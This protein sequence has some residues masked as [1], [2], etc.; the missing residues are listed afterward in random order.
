MVGESAFV[1]W[2]YAKEN[3][4][5]EPLVHI[6]DFRMDFGD[7]TVIEDLSFDVHAGETFGFLGSN[8]SGKTTTLRALLGIYQPTAGVG[9]AEGSV[10][11]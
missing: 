7:T 3:T 9:G 10:D 2:G 6:K 11:S 1:G 4:M 5:S 8:G